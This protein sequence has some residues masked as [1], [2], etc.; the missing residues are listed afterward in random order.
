MTLSEIQKLLQATVV[1]GSDKTSQTIDYAFASDL[2]SDVLTLKSSQI[3]LITGLCNIQTMRTMEMADLNTVIFVRGK[4]AT[5]DMIE[6]AQENN[7][8]VLQT[9]YSMF[10]TSGI[11]WEAG[12]KPVF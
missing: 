9:D 1:C 11:L 7:M 2:M 5:E 4:K 6:I 3:M 10:R 8:I 12:I